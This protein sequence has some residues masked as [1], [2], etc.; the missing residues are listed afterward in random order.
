MFGLQQ[1]ILQVRY[2]P[3]PAMAA[4]SCELIAPLPDQGLPR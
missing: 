3:T 2:K 4:W 1:G